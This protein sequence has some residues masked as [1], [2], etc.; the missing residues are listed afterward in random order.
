MVFHLACRSLDRGAAEDIVQ[1]VFLAVWRKA[2]TFDPLKGPVRAWLLGVTR[3]RILDE[4]RARGRRPRLEGAPEGLELKAQDPLPDEAAWSAYRKAA[5][6]RALAALPEPQRRALQLAYFSELSQEGVADALNIPLGTAKTRIR[7]GLRGLAGRLAVLVACLLLAVGISAAGLA[8][9]RQEASAA[10]ALELLAN[11]SL[12]VLKLLPPGGGGEAGLH[13]AFRG[14]PGRNLAV[15]TLSRF[16]PPPG[17]A[18]YVL[19]LEGG[20][21]LT[22]VDLPDPDRDGRALRVL[23]GDLPGGNWPSSLR[24]TAERGRSGKPT[25]PV[26]ARWEAPSGAGEP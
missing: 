14:I 17:G 11:S 8:R 4:L 25:G 10:R 9:R 18:R 24:I 5:L 16:P 26:A 19:W 12:R 2:G 6:A 13:A 22:R 15:V 23:E 7:S 1:E 21:A 3:N 20:G